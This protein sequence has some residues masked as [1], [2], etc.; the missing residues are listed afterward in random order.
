[1]NIAARALV[2]LAAI[3]FFS[4]C[5]ITLPDY[6]RTNEALAPSPR[7]IVGRVVAVDPARGYAF[8]EL[9]A[10]APPSASAEGNELV[11]R[12]ADLKETA[13]LRASRQL[14]ARTLGTHVMSGSP[15]IGEEVI[16]IAP[17]MQ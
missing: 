9:T 7:L 8:I 12:T 16:W 3:S 15:G 10:D 13:R 4:G 11:V 6:R 2:A 5:N 14:R 17:A 1:M